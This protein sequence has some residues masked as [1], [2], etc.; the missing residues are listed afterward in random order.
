MMKLLK[1]KIKKAGEDPDTN[2]LLSDQLSRNVI[3]FLKDHKQE[4]RGML[5]LSALVSHSQCC[6]LWL[7]LQNNP[8]MDLK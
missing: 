2:S 3:L 5:P 4:G 7:S 1:K 8:T 6:L